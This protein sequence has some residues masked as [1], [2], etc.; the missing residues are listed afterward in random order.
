LRCAWS[1]DGSKVS[2]GSADRFVYIWDTTSNRIVY[3]L[4]G[5]RGS[6]ND[7]DFHP[8]EQLVIEIIRTL[9]PHLKKS[10]IC[11]AIEN[12]DRFPSTTLRRIIQQTDPLS[13]GICLDTANSLGANEGVNEII[14]TLGPF[15]VNLHIKDIT[16]HRLSHKMGFI[17]EGCAAGFGILNIPSIIKQLKPYNK[18][19][20]VT[21]EVWSQPEATV[22]QSIAREKQWVEASIHYLKNVLI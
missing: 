21:L 14:E 9:L 15:T 13:V 5:H 3:K 12:H 7:V 6:V 2:A 4:P 20:T 1:P 19:K 22:E 18:C 17:I 11:L 16:I 8:D 10:G